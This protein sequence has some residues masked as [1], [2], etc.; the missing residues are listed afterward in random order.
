MSVSRAI[1]FDKDGVINSDRGVYGITEEPEFLPGIDSIISSCRSK[2]FQIIIVTNQ[3]AVAR[4]IVSEESLRKLLDDFKN[5]LAAKNKNA[6]IDSMYYCPHHPNANL[7]RYR[8]SCSCRKPKPGMIL[9]ACSDLN[10]DPRKS[11]AVGDRISDVIAGHLAGCTT[12]Q[13]LSGQH[14]SKMIE[15]DLVLDHEIGPD[16]TITDLSQ[17]EDIIK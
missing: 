15:T 12:I 11:Y 8:L 2:G 10:I 9:Q 13:F 14:D 6:I 7:Q 17:L 16:F 3:P 4:G 5:K 1:F